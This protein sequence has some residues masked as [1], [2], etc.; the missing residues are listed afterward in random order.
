MRTHIDRPGQVMYHRY[1]D[2]YVIHAAG[3]DFRETEVTR[4]GATIAFAVTYRRILEAFVD[5]SLPTLRLLP[6]SGGVFS[7]PWSEAM[8]ELTAVALLEGIAALD[9]VRRE[10]L[11]S[12]STLELCIYMGDKC[13]AFAA[14]WRFACLQIAHC[15]ADESALLQPPPALGSE[16]GAGTGSSPLEAGTRGGPLR[17]E[18]LRGS[19]VAPPA[20]VGRELEAMGRSAPVEGQGPEVARGSIAEP[21]PEPRDDVASG[22]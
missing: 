8:P 14:A 12:R 17:P 3:P 10:E 2:T 4:E 1:G 7:G 20:E 6:V 18:P 9:E 5:S 15:G 22:A 21:A 19:V 16:E 11:L 13:D